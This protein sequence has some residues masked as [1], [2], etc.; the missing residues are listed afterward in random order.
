MS[1]LINKSQVIKQLK[2]DDDDVGLIM[3]RRSAVIKSR[4]FH[5]E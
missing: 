4:G 3:R 2:G 1:R 5:L